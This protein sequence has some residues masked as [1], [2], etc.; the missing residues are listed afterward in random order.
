MKEINIRIPGFL[1]AGKTWGN[2]ENPP[3]LALH[4][5]LDNANSFTSVAPYLQQDFYFIAVDLPG[6]GHSSHLPEGCNY[7]FFDAVFIIIELI[8]ALKLGK[9]H[10]LG[11]S[12]GAC[13]SSLHAGVAPEQLFSLYLIE[14]LGPFSA[15][16][17]T[18]CKQLA[19][20]AQFITRPRKKTKGYE[21]FEQATL[22][23]SAKGY[24]S[25]DLARTLCER[26]LIK[27]E[28]R[29]Y[30]RHDQRLMVP[31]PLRM[32]ED[33]ILSFLG[34]I[35]SKTQLLLANKG[36]SFDTNIMK[37]RIKAVKN[38]TVKQLVGGHHIHMEEPEAVGP[39]LANFYHSF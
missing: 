11:H 22:A 6:H 34:N 29:Y 19:N 20:Y 7:H 1:I 36:F 31:S 13:A 30:W 26:S 5:W 24:I 37:N 12:M 9:V 2:P 16:A 23:R 39:L 17:E 10:L 21:S 35:R 25:R 18:A 15:P 38:L 4:G 33:Q 3:I 8:N 14:A 27:R 28:G 32:T